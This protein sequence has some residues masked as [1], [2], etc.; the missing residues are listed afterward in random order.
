[1]IIQFNADMVVFTDADNHAGQ[2]PLAYKAINQKRNQKDIKSS[3]LKCFGHD[4][5]LSKTIVAP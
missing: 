4:R 2:D 5:Y 1:M 3:V